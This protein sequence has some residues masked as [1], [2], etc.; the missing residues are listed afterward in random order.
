MYKWGTCGVHE[1]HV[2]PAE[3][4]TVMSSCLQ[5]PH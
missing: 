5:E 2:R 4:D 3:A 1:N